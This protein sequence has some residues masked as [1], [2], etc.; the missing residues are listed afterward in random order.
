MPEHIFL[1]PRSNETAYDNLK[2]SVIHGRDYSE[3]ERLLDANGK[4][5]LNNGS[6]LYAWG[7]VQNLKTRW[8]RMEAGDLILFYARGEFV[9]S[10]RCVYKQLSSELSDALWPRS[11]RFNKPWSCVFFLNDIKPVKIPLSVINELGPYHFK[12]VMGFQSVSDA[13]VR[14]IIEKYG[15]TEEFLDAFPAAGAHRR[16]LP[17]REGS[18]PQ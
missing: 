4:K 18:G 11:A 2:S 5:V 14:H 13:C 3:L 15:S 10:G 7:N 1:A 8:D 6:R 12:A 17:D 9:Y 16:R